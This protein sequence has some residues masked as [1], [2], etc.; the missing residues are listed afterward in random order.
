[1]VAGNRNS[2]RVSVNYGDLS[3]DLLQLAANKSNRPS[4]KLSTRDTN[5]NSAGTSPYVNNDNHNN[6]NDEGSSNSR[7]L[8]NQRSF[9]DEALAK[10]S[11]NFQ[12]DSLEI[13]PTITVDAIS[14]NINSGASSNRNKR[15]SYVATPT[16]IDDSKQDFHSKR[17]SSYNEYQQFSAQTQPQNPATGK[18][19]PLSIRIKKNPNRYS[20]FDGS[21]P[22]KAKLVRQ[23]L[24]PIDTSGSESFSPHASSPTGLGLDSILK[25]NSSIY[26]PKKVKDIDD[27]DEDEEEDFPH[28]RYPKSATNSTFPDTSKDKETN[29]FGG[30]HFD[31]KM[32]SRPVN[33]NVSRHSRSK[34]FNFH[35][36]NK[37]LTVKPI[38]SPQITSPVLN[39]KPNASFEDIRDE[40]PH[41][42]PIH[43]KSKQSL[44][45]LVKIFPE[46]PEDNGGNSAGA[47]VPAS[48]KDISLFGLKNLLMLVFVVNNFGLLL[49]YYKNY[50]TVDSIH[51]VVFVFRYNSDIQFFL[52]CVSLTPLYYI[53]TYIVE[54]VL[55]FLT[56]KK[57][58]SLIRNKFSSSSLGGGN[59]KADNNYLV[60]RD[61]LSFKLTNNLL[62]T[63]YLLPIFVILYFSAVILVFGVNNIIIIR[64]IYNPILGSVL[65]LHTIVCMF[66]IISFA[67]TNKNLRELYFKSINSAKYQRYLK[68]KKHLINSDGTVNLT[69]EAPQGVDS[70][71]LS[72][73]MTGSQLAETINSL[74]QRKNSDEKRD[75]GEPEMDHSLD[76][77]K[78]FID[79]NLQP[80]FYE[81]N[82]YP[83]N[84]TM[85]DIFYFSAV[86]TLVY[87]PMY[88]SSGKINWKYVID[89]LLEIAAMT[90]VIFYLCSQYAVPI[91]KDSIL[92]TF[93][94]S[95][96]GFQAPN[97]T[98]FPSSSTPS[99]D[100]A[101]IG[102]LK[103]VELL[104]K[105]A[106]ISILIW[107]ITYYVVFHDYLNF[108]AEVTM[109]NDR[110]FYVQ[111]WNSR[112]V[113]AYWKTWNKV[114]TNFFDRHFYKP[115]LITRERHL[116]TS[117]TEDPNGGS[118]GER[119]SGVN[120]S[121]SAKMNFFIFFIMAVMQELVVGVPT[122]NMM[123]ISFICI[124]MQ[125][126]LSLLTNPLDNLR[127]ENNTLGNGIFWVSFL[128]GQPLCI[129]LY[130]FTWN[131]KYGELSSY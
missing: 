81:G 87:Q 49:E 83:N 16:L 68:H 116:L 54:K 18:T 107:L 56:L 89:K 72:G 38:P 32:R 41:C 57:F 98:S 13:A 12:G 73:R 1:M 106:D 47:K 111:W 14:G 70:E 103:L 26:Q 77:D 30:N 112:S 130:Y 88:P 62:P 82:Y 92:N 75:I 46:S 55:Y 3:E 85:N 97:I 2:K 120:S 40:Y 128:I 91:L 69:H 9:N 118:A 4:P 51:S 24:S 102:Q 119:E 6:N 79:Q 101:F 15:V 61:D 60:G 110:E 63:N 95:H 25:N 45:S 93:N 36:R 22:N 104:I 52:L 115:L 86:P 27:E 23:M 80:S 5:N 59:S 129:L 37:S 105:L 44:L 125:S 7:P 43:T 78:D 21:D 48:Q 20:S 74:K 53:Y 123:G 8:K 19:R 33:S 131:I 109:F 96:H 11:G 35:S 10:L 126:P 121:G 28:F 108:M 117:S 71:L 17:H 65:E 66:K 113:G 39:I 42:I 76:S 31:N 90:S 58:N 127:G 29:P 67:L 34:S 124:I 64:F 94:L 100:S 50:F 122:G 114:F 99:D 84:I